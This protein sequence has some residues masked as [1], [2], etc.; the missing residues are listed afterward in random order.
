MNERACGVRYLLAS[1]LQW[2]G[3]CFPSESRRESHA[4][5]LIRN[6][7][8]Q[9]LRSV[10]QTSCC[11]FVCFFIKF[12][13]CLREGKTLYTPEAGTRGK[14][15]LPFSLP[16]GPPGWGISH[17]VWVSD[18]WAMPALRR[19]TSPQLSSKTVDWA[20]CSVT[21]WLQFR[22]TWPSVSKSGSEC[23]EHKTSG[24]EKSLQNISWEPWVLNVGE[25]RP[26]AVTSSLFFFFLQF[27]N[28]H[29]SDSHKFKSKEHTSGHTCS[30]LS[31]GAIHVKAKWKP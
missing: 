15:W 18:M 22:L 28:L 14:V 29:Y 26:D 10:T 31:R 21:R 17:V 13:E 24:L 9:P 3:C 7:A 1:K 5:G 27:R 4:G 6:S 19:S 11:Q 8:L 12:Y 30:W 23:A 25:V 16:D 2:D 20:S